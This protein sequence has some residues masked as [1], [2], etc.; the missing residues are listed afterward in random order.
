MAPHRAPALDGDA[1]DDAGDDYGDDGV[2]DRQ[3]E[4]HQRAALSMTP[5]L[6][7]PSVRAW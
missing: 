2:G 6:T 7:K 3:T 5:R 1:E 4:G